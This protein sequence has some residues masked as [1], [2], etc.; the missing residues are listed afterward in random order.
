MRV[1]PKAPVKMEVS[2]PQNS[3]K[4]TV[5]K[6]AQSQMLI[7]LKR[8]PASFLLSVE[9]LASAQVTIILTT[10]RDLFI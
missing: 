5:Q 9:K 10:E 3:S 4:S 8:V 6:P 2:L 1:P 7:L